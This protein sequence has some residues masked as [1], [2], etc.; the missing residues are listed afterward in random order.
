MNNVRTDI[1]R[2]E[3]KAGDGL[4][5]YVCECCGMAALNDYRGE[6]SD[7]PFCPWCGKTMI[8]STLVDRTED[9]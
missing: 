6:S 7:T 4:N 8:N 5:C 2:W 1:S 3:W 9:K